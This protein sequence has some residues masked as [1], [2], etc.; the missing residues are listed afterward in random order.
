MCIRDRV[1]T[2]DNDAVGFTVTQTG[3]PAATSV[4]EQN[5]TTDTFQVKLNAEPSGNVVINVVS[6][7][8]S[9]ATVSAA[10]LTFTPSNW[11]TDQTI[12]VTGVDDFLDDGDITANT[13]LSINQ[14]STVAEYDGVGSQNVA[15]TTV[16]NDAVGF[17]VTLSGN[18]TSVNEQ[19]TTTDTFQV[20]LNAEPSG[21]VVINVVSGDTSEATVSAASLTFTPSNW[22]TDQ[23]ITVTGVDDFL[24]DGDI[25]ANTV[26]SINQG[27]TVAEYDGVGSQNVAVTTVDNDTAGFTVVQSGGS[28]SVNESGTTDTFTVVLTAQ[29]S[30]NVVINVVSGDTGEATVSAASLTFT[31]V[32]WLSRIHI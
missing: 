16:D 22:S 25:T 26:L 6:G 20:K 17:T 31:T 1:T 21:N 28:T 14:G 11:S 13:V 4:N 10:S 5:T 9:E 24:D 8:T 7:D 30:G 3:S 15:V 32:N 27:S 19:N 29:P 12:T 23:T 2:V 18:S